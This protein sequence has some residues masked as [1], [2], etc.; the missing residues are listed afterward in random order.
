M[1][2]RISS[3]T[4]ALRQERAVSAPRTT[5]YLSP[6]AALAVATASSMSPLRK[7]KPAGGLRRVVAEHELWT[8]P[9]PAVRLAFLG[10]GELVGAIA[11]E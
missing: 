2:T 5:T 7:V 6:A 3:S 4:P 9:C 8:G 11:D 10:L 1:C